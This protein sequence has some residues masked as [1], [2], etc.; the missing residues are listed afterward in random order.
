MLT[1]RGW[2]MT[3]R[4]FAAC[5]LLFPLAWL[6]VGCAGIRP[7]HVALFCEHD[8][9]ETSGHNPQRTSTNKVGGTATY[10]LPR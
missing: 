2:Q 10:D 5:L 9:A 1:A 4:R 8:E 7:D 6:C 3:R